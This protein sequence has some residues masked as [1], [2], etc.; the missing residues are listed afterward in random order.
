M[1]RIY[2][3]PLLRGIG[4]TT[5][6]LGTLIAYGLAHRDGANL[7]PSGLPNVAQ[8]PSVARA[9]SSTN[10]TTASTADENEEV[11]KEV[12]GSPY[13]EWMGFIGTAVIATSFFVEGFAR[14]KDQN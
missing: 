10:L 5:V 14:R 8:P 11:A 9:G 6:L 1:A 12:L 7:S 2:W 13:F 4:T 3:P